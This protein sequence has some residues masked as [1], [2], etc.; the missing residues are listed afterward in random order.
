M[1]GG[2]VHRP[3]K[4]QLRS[5]V[6]DTALYMEKSMSKVSMKQKLIILIVIIVVLAVAI[7]IAVNKQ[8]GGIGGAS[9][10]NSEIANDGYVMED[11]ATVQVDIPDKEKKAK[12]TTEAAA[13]E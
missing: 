11:T 8:S 13:N 9:A 3:I 5:A 2:A 1:S 12:K 6:Q 10:G 7:F 4:K